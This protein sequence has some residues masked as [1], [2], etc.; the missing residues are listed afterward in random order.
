MVV[1]SECLF[2]FVVFFFVEV[3]ELCCV[4][5]GVFLLFGM[6]EIVEFGFVLGVVY[7]DDLLGLYVVF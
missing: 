4:V 6:V 7:D 2:L 5:F 1:G 3:F